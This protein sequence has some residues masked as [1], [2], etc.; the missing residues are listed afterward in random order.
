M[1]T[2]TACTRCSKLRHPGRINNTG[3]VNAGI[4]SD[5]IQATSPI[6]PVRFFAL[7]ELGLLLTTLGNA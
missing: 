1:S 2:L 6:Q 3:V 7:T 5:C 4:C